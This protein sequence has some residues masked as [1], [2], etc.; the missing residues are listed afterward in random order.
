METPASTSKQQ[1]D[2]LSQGA[3]QAVDRAAQAASSAADRVSEKYEE[4]YAM[5]EDWVE[6]GREYV[7][8]HPVAAVGMALA[9]GWLL[10]MIL[11]R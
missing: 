10:G 9:A 11:R 4:L 5:S 3:H 2:R 7:R 6:T 1:V 8:E